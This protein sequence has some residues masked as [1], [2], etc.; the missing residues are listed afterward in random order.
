MLPGCTMSSTSVMRSSSRSCSDIFDS[1]LAC[2][3][4]QNLLKDSF[5]SL[6]ETVS[7]KKL[8]APDFSAAIAALT[9][10]FLEGDASAAFFRVLICPALDRALIAAPGTPRRIAEPAP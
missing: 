8:V 9:K 3:F 2:C 5:L 1:F 6:S 7:E 10:A 4:S